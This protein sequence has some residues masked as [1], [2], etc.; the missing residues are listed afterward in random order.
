[1]EEPTINSHDENRLHNSRSFLS[2]YQDYLGEFVYGG[3]DG[4]VT[5]FAVVA[6][7]VGAGLDSAIIIILGF[8]NLLADGFSM[9]VGAYL[10][11]RS[12][13]ANYEK[14]QRVEYWEVDN[15]P[16]EE[17]E[18][19][20]K[21][22]REK[23]FEGK[24]LEEVVAVIT[25]DKDRW[26]DTMMKEELQMMKDHRSPIKVGAV[27][28][29]AFILIGFIPLSLYLWDY[30]F[31]FKGNLF[32]ATSVL[33]GLGFAIVGWLK[34]YVTETSTWKGILETLVLGALAAGVAYFVGDWL[35]Q[36]IRG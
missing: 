5:T 7:S 18:E 11:S 28:Y 20:R 6:G 30:L 3:I 13:H 24:L 16:E 22:Y 25:A 36:I 33:T 21:I 29:L 12:E 35:E 17:R 2:K 1:M 31:G 14:H 26:V 9:S 4:S 27:T 34:T 10:S 15:M 23:G 8:A 32:L 19:V